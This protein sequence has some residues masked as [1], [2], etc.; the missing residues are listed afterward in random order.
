MDSCIFRF[1]SSC[2]W[3]GYF[4]YNRNRAKELS[5]DDEDNEYNEENENDNEYDEYGEDEEDNEYDEYNE[6]NEY[7]EYSEDDADI[8]D[9]EYILTNSSSDKLSKR[10][11][12]NLSKE[13]LRLARNEIYARHGRLFQ[14]EELQSYFDSKSWYEGFIPAEEFSDSEELNSIERKNILLIKEYESK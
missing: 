6:E 13:E 12:K 4:T 9:N 11:L 10:D 2:Q 8:K 5:L 7:D 1:R 3:Y 14:D